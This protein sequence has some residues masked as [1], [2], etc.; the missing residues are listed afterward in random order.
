MQV[1]QFVVEL[2]MQ[3]FRDKSKVNAIESQGKLDDLEKFPVN[4]NS[5]SR[6]AVD[7][8]PDFGTTTALGRP[9]MNT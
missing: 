5:S 9:R 4:N 8:Q 7:A 1:A 2:I 6:S 3:C